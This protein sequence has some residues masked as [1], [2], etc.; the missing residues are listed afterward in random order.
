MYQVKFLII[1]HHANP[2]VMCRVVS[3]RARSQEL[4]HRQRL[5]LH[6]AGCVHAS[7]S[8]SLPIPTAATSEP[9]TSPSPCF[10]FWVRGYCPLF[11]FWGTKNPHSTSFFEFWLQGYFGLTLPITTT[12]GVER[13]GALPPLQNTSLQMSKAPKAGTYVYPQ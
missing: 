2:N 7:L 12:A 6:A 13:G 1:S 10:L 8:L 11:G 5:P 3:S 9:N 4:A